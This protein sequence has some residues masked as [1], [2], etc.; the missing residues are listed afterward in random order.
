MNEW[1]QNSELPTWD[2]EIPYTY[3]VNTD[4]PNT[5]IE[6]AKATIELTIQYSNLDS[7]DSWDYFDNKDHWKQFISEEHIYELQF[8]KFDDVIHGNYDE[9]SPS[10][11]CKKNING[12]YKKKTVTVANYKKRID[13]TPEPYEYVEELKG[14]FKSFDFD[15]GTCKLPNNTL[16]GKTVC[17]L[18]EKFIESKDPHFDP[19]DAEDEPNYILFFKENHCLVHLFTD[20]EKLSMF[21][22]RPNFNNKPDSMWTYFFCEGYRD[23]VP[24][25]GVRGIGARKTGDNTVDLLID[26]I[27]NLKD[28]DTESISHLVFEAGNN[29]ARGTHDDGVVTLYTFES[30][31]LSNPVKDMSDID[32][33]NLQNYVITCVNTYE[34]SKLLDEQTRCEMVPGFVFD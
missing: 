13:D 26:D 14:E 30:S 5:D 18:N 2:P 16:L 22:I 12:T 17:F 20:K 4:T 27:R 34:N 29:T 32:F 10:Y 19:C 9:S 7:Q 6:S 21:K 3:R 15:Y 1:E 23:D 33:D 24:F 8:D 31:D 11:L 25:V 28:A